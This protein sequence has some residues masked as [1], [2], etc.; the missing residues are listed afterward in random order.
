M[1]TP[2]T[3]AGLS[4]IRH[5]VVLVGCQ[6]SGTTMSGQVMGAHPNAFLIDENDGL[7]RWF[8][9]LLEGKLD[10]LASST[11]AL[12]VK[13]NTKY[14]TAHSKLKHDPSGIVALK[15]EITHLVLKA[16]NL[17]YHY[18][19]LSRIG[20]PTTVLYAARDVLPVI[21]S[22]ARLSH[23]NFIENQLKL[24]EQRTDVQN[25]FRREYAVLKDET[26]P[27]DTRRAALWVIKTGL[28]EQFQNRQLPV[29]HFRYE[30]FVQNSQQHCAEMAA[31]SGLSYH[32][33]LHHHHTIYVGTGP[34]GTDRTRP[35]DTQSLK[36]ATT[37]NAEAGSG[38]PGSAGSRACQAGT[39]MPDNT[40]VLST[41]EFTDSIDELTMPLRTALH[42]TTPKA[43][44]A[45]G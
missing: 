31:I 36:G 4:G 18:D 14:A 10:E 22:M 8:N 38:Q 39:D 30:D 41:T 19:E 21:R 34:G 9:G 12:L 26:L 35:I 17:T 40:N 6:R 42:Y 2:N 1:I 25:L 44:H 5:L 23:I 15:P 28:F 37:P 32:E 33:Y 43:R 27:D 7:Y 29:Y 45:T 13:A 24:L 20:F 11:Q 16:P 3:I